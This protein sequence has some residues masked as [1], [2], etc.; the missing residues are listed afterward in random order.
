MT[1]CG[2]F[3]PFTGE[4]EFADGRAGTRSLDDSATALCHQMQCYAGRGPCERVH[5]RRYN[6]SIP[7]PGNLYFSLLSKLWVSNVFIRSRKK[8][9]TLMHSTLNRRCQVVGQLTN[10]KM[11]MVDFRRDQLS[12]PGQGVVVRSRGGRPRGERNTRGIG[13]RSAKG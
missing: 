9:T 7:Y 6:P 4:G 11:K 5:G 12:V 2:Q 13:A 8:T 10:L 3:F 1:P